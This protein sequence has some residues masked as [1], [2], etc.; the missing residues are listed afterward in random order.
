MAGDFGDVI[1]SHQVTDASEYDTPPSKRRKEPAAE[2][3]SSDEKFL[4][5]LG[6]IVKSATEPSTRNGS[7]EQEFGRFV[8]AC[9]ENLAD[10][11]I[12]DDAMEAIQQVLTNAKKKCR[13]KANV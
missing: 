4:L 8:A 11:E 6:E 1:D 10:E 3:E 5:G 12:K 13:G 7:E 9:L 2:R